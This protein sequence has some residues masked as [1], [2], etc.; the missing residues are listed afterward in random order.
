MRLHHGDDLVRGRG[1]G[2][3]QHRGDFDRVMA[4]IVENDR[5]LPLA[6]AGEATLDAAEA[7]Q[8]LGDVLDADAKLIG[9]RDRRSGVERVVMARHRQDEVG[10]NLFAVR[11]GGRAG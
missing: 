3:A 4:V 9:D 8:P 6:G 7:R 1:A 5:A 11:A 10:Q 2:R